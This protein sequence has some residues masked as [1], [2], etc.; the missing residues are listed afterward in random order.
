MNKR[1]AKAVKE[2]TRKTSINL[3]KL[4]AVLIHTLLTEQLSHSVTNTAFMSM[5]NRTL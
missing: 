5:T 1:V 4:Q 3:I 2:K